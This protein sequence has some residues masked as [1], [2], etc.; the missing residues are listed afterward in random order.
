MVLSLTDVLGILDVFGVL[1]VHLS[2]AHALCCGENNEPCAGCFLCGSQSQCSACYSPPRLS[3]LAAAPPDIARGNRQN[4][5]NPSI[6]AVHL[7]LHGHCATLRE[8]AAVPS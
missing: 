6:E 4:T 8:R 5:C 2:T 7:C 1:G 3:T